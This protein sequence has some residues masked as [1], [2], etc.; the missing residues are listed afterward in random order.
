[1]VPSEDPTEGESVAATPASLA[2]ARAVVP[3][4][5]RGADRGGAGTGR[6]RLASFRTPGCSTRA[7]R[8]A[9]A[10]A[11]DSPA[12]AGVNGVWGIAGRVTGA[13][14]DRMIEVAASVTDTGADAAIDPATGS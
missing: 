12:E 4:S 14:G 3:P 13:A 2:P 7:T 6:E 5:A 10:A 11:T 1:M 8:A 9:A